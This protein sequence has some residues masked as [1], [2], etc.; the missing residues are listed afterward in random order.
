MD[1]D[2][3]DIDVID[4]L[5]KLKDASGAYPQEMLALRRQGYLHQVAEVIGGGGLALGLKE[6]LKSGKGAGAGTSPA[7]GTLVEALLVIAIVAEAG[8]VAYLYRDKVM[9]FFQSFSNQ[10]R[11]EEVSNPPVQ[12]SLIPATGLTP[13]LMET[14]TLTVTN[15]PVTVTPVSTPSIELAAEPTQQ[16]NETG[17][18]GGGNEGTAGSGS[19]G[20]SQ[21]V[22]T[23]NP[24][25]NNND[26]DNGN[27]GNHYGQTP[28]PERTKEPGNDNS[29]QK[30][31]EKNQSR[32][33][34]IH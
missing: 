10:P 17:S 13:T 33:E 2:P 19:G 20:G 7:A 5:K 3:K 16:N 15:T 31:E 32:K 6:T 25:A 9:D 34:Y 26:N 30:Q 27:N 12:P 18:A 29:Q 22:S 8:A 11:V 4:L 1:Y 14:P 24:N 21:S 28:K 23:P